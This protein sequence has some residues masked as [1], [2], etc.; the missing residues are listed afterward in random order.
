MANTSAKTISFYAQRSRENTVKLRELLE[1]LPSFCEDFFRGIQNTTGSL[2]RLAYGYDLKLFFDY[3]SAHHEH[4]QNKDL[5]NLTIQDM[6]HISARDIERFI[7]YISLYSPEPDRTMENNEKGKARKIAA[8]RTM[9]KYFFKKELLPSNVAALV[10]LPKIHEKAIIRLEVDEVVK[11]LDEVESGDKLTE[12]QKIYHEQT[13]LRDLAMLTLFLG[14]GIR[15]SECVGLNIED[16]DFESYSFVVTRKGGSQSALFL[17]D[18]IAGALSAYLDERV[19]IQAAEGDEHALF[20]SL[21]K[22]RMTPRAV[23]NLVKK[24]ARIVTPLKKITPHKLRSTFGTSLY[25]ETGDIYLVADVLGHKD[26]NTTR[27]HYAAMSE[28]RRRTAA[29]VTKLRDNP[30]VYSH[31]YSMNE[32]E[33]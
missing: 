27:K 3:L 31:D 12:R 20:L 1:F 11:L 2:T 23:Q 28:D 7:D 9:F 13:K 8:L 4:F 24:Y 21:Q 19:K 6:E 5:K 17:N 14:T 30:V 10:E 16:I 18:E 29:K 32:K 15:I 26:V 33:K 22:K 25:G